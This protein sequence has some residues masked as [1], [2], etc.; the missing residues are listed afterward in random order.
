MIRS[1]ARKRREELATAEFTDWRGQAVAVGSM[2]VFPYAWGGQ[3]LALLEGQI[4]EIVSGSEDDEVAY[5]VDL[6]YDNGDYHRK[7]FWVTVRQSLVT[8]VEHR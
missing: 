6:H 7:R 8:K 2:V 5:K 1:D 4:I 3:R